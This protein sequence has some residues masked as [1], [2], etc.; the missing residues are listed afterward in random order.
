[1]SL[2]KTVQALVTEQ[3]V[4][5]CNDEPDSC[6]RPF[7]SGGFV[8]LTGNSKDQK[9]ITVLRDLAGS[10][11]CIKEGIL[12]VSHE[13]WCNSNVL[14]RGVG[15]VNV[16]APLHRVHLQ[17]PLRIGW[18]DIA[19]LPA[20]P[21]AGIDFLL[22]NDIAGGQV[23]PAPVIV[24]TPVIAEAATGSQVSPEVFPTCAVTRAQTK[25]YGLDLSDSFLTT[26]R[27]LEAVMTGQKVNLRLN[28]LTRS[29]LPPVQWL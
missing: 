4:G 29:R 24:D 5:S 14:M 17:C 3:S 2:C 11:S 12:L 7:I 13:T 6:F 20:L 15:M 21:V 25:K 19:V 16:C 9:S 23:K 26:E 18:F 27:S 22:G 1:M 28:L 8:S 10:Q